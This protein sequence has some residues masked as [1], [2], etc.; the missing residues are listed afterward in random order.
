MYFLLE[1]KPSKKDELPND[2]PKAFCELPPTT[3]KTQ[4]SEES[5][6]RAHAQVA[7]SKLWPINHGK[8]VLNF[9]IINEDDLASVGLNA[10]NIKSWAEKWN[11]HPYSTVIP[12][13]RSSGDSNSDIRIK[14]SKQFLPMGCYSFCSADPNGR[15][16]SAVGVD[17][18]LVD[19]SEPTMVLGFIKGRSDYNKHIVIHEFGHALGMEH[20]HQRSMFWSVAKKFIDV[21]KMKKDK[22]LK[23]TDIDGDY[24]EILQCGDGSDKYDPDSVMHY[25]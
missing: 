6:A 21:D 1:P 22:S 9:Y 18:E 11:Q 10:D 5:D 23:N 12:K 15:S 16:R 19:K 13:L 24:L 14:I 20:E 3:V 2:V 7:T 17:A 8:D 25:W 4:Y